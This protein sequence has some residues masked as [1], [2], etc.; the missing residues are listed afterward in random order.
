VEAVRRQ[1]L[2]PYRGIKE[3]HRGEKSEAATA[4]HRQEKRFQQERGERT[5]LCWF[6]PVCLEAGRQCEAG[7]ARSGSV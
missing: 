5:F 4:Q 6:H 7:G 1:Q 2:L 3:F